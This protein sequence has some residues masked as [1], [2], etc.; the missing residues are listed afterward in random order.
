MLRGLSM[1]DPW[2][3]VRKGEDLVWLGFLSC[4]SSS[5]ATL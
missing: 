5:I 4:N 3:P 1:W 2:G